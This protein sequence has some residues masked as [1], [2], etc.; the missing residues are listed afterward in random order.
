VIP[1]RG[2]TRIVIGVPTQAPNDPKVWRCVGK[3]IGHRTGLP[4]AGEDGEEEPTHTVLLRSGRG[5]TPE[6]AEEDVLRQLRFVYGES[7]VSPLIAER[8]SNAP[9]APVAP[10]PTAAVRP[11]WRA[12][13]GRFLK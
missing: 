6:A 10:P 13:F 11:W 2:G 9:P 5:S 8:R 1:F 3:I 7:R 4:W 12:L